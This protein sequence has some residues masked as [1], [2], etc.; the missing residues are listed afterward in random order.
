LLHTDQYLESACHGCPIRTERAKKRTKSKALVINFIHKVPLRQCKK[1]RKEKKKI[2]D[3]D[4]I[5]IL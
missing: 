4:L 3:E 2:M 1:K 5:L